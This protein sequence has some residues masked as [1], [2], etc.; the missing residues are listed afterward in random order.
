[1]RG[2]SYVGFTVN[3]R[4]IL[5][6]NGVLVA[7]AHRTRRLR[8]CEMLLVIHGF[9]S[10]TQ[11][12]QFEWAWQNPRTSLAVREAAARLGV[13][14]R[15]TAPRIK[16]RVACAMLNVAPWRDLPL[17]AHFLSRDM[18]EHARGHGEAPPEHIAFEFGTM[19]DLKAAVAAA[20][21]GDEEDEEDEEERGEGEEESRAS[22]SQTMMTTRSE[23][24][25]VSEASVPANGGVVWGVG[26]EELERDDDRADGDDDREAL[27]DVV[28]LCVDDDEDKENRPASV[29]ADAFAPP[30]TY[31]EP[32]SSAAA[33]SSESESPE[34]RPL[35]ERLFRRERAR[36]GDG[37]RGGVEKRRTSAP[38]RRRHK[39]V[40]DVD[41]HFFH[42]RRLVDSILFSLKAR[43]RREGGGAAR[44]GSPAAR[45]SSAARAATRIDF[46]AAANAR[47]SSRGAPE[48]RSNHRANARVRARGKPK[49]FGNPANARRLPSGRTPRRG[50]PRVQGRRGTSRRVRRRLT[51]RLLDRRRSS[52][53]QCPPSRIA[54]IASIARLALAANSSASATS[55]TRP[56]SAKTRIGTTGA[57][58]SARA[59]SAFSGWSNPAGARTCA[60]PSSSARA[61]DPTPAL[62][63]RHA[64]FGR[65]RRRSAQGSARTCGG[66]GV[67]QAESAVSGWRV[68]S[69]AE[70]RDVKHSGSECV[71]GAEGV[72]A[73]AVVAA[74]F[75]SL[76]K[77][78][79]AFAFAFDP[80]LRTRSIAATAARKN[81]RACGG[82][83]VPATNTNGRGWSRRNAESSGS[84]LVGFTFVAGSSG[85]VSVGKPQ[86][87]AFA[88]GHSASGGAN[89]SG[90][91][92]STPPRARNHSRNTPGEEVA[93]EDEGGWCASREMVL[94]P[95]A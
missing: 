33:S 37:R 1:M 48:R 49:I 39:P 17:T 36:G 47:A 93:N 32:E 25:E 63:T 14:D 86:R 51:R 79:L 53:A 74:F 4:R 7:G 69:S 57:S 80:R 89:H 83:P 68:R 8:P 58:T 75:R 91:M 29:D 50:T 6:H 92:H 18:L 65:M 95:V 15:S 22:E 72:A 3:P 55:S 71:E 64:Q 11:A 2:R 88:E 78:T 26:D 94:L 59:L 56:A 52:I 70:A 76:S 13:G 40:T 31:S 84:R 10:K 28:D 66:R 24:E 27:V 90:H 61:T 85:S 16:V 67:G 23:D 12:L 43:A 42:S 20:G 44:P 5:Q 19:D 81:A 54:S 34:A 30:P 38:G 45:R 73:V 46:L 77:K 21:R 35:A 41:T 87:V 82:F 9:P 62:C 60:A